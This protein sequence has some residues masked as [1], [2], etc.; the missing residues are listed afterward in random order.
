MSTSV[1]LSPVNQRVPSRAAN[2]LPLRI[3]GVLHAPHTTFAAVAQSPR[4]IGVLGLTLVVTFAAS[5]ALLETEVGR[6][7]LVDQW[8]RSAIA[9]GQPVDDARYATLARASEHGAL[10]AAVTALAS[11]PVLVFGLSLLLFAVFTGMLR[12]T[13]TYRQV[14][15][16]VAYAGVIL[17]LRQVVVAPL[18]YARETLASP[19]TLNVLF[20]M[21]DEA[22]PLAR[23]FGVIDLFVVWW[24]SALAIGVAVLYRRRARPLVV[25]FIGAYIAAGRTTGARHGARGRERR[26]TAEV[27]DHRCLV[28]T[29]G[30]RGRRRESGSA[31]RIC[32]RSTRKRCGTAT[33]RRSSRRRARSSRS[34]RSTSPR[35]RW[36]ASRALPS[37]KD[38]ASRP[39]SFSSRSTRNRSQVSSSAARR[40]SPPR[41]RRSSRR[42]PA[43]SRRAPRWTCRSRT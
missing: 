41:G 25:G 7:A 18:N 11:G 15:A 4:W 36:A 39:A 20:A 6:L 37:R 23:F 30:H 3:A 22:S 42:A 34:G 24:A 35:T 8:E 38:S 26:E 32:P 31:T 10:Y 21:L 16:V 1:P 9:F 17:A 13:A 5:A 40:A 27:V 2:S 33:S 43:S 19:A 28:V 29:R 12:G 14:V